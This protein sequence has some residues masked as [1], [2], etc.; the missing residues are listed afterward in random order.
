MA[1]WQSAVLRRRRRPGQRRLRACRLRCRR[2]LS[3]A[4]C[5][6]TRLPHLAPAHGGRLRQGRCSGGEHI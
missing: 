6:R 2:F 4:V 1:R 3:W 5:A